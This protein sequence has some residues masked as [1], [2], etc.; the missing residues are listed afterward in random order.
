[1]SWGVPSLSIGIFHSSRT[2]SNSSSLRPIALCIISVG[3]APG[4]TVLTLIFGAKKSLLA[5]DKNRISH[6]PNVENYWTHLAN[7]IE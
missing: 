1:M 2:L 4:A 3:I 7:E 6:Q 5:F